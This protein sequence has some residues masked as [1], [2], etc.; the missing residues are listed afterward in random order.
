MRTAITIFTVIMAIGFVSPLFHQDTV[1]YPANDVNAI[2]EGAPI[3]H[4]VSHAPADL[5]LLWF[6]GGGLT[7]GAGAL[8]MR[9]AKKREGKNLLARIAGVVFFIIGAFM[10]GFTTLFFAIHELEMSQITAHEPNYAGILGSF[11][12]GLTLLVGSYFLCFG[13]DRETTMNS[14]PH[15]NSLSKGFYVGS[16]AIAPA[17]SIALFVWAGIRFS[18]KGPLAALS[19]VPVIYLSVVF[20]VLIYK[21]WSGIQDGYARTTPGKAVGFLFI[22]F[23]NFYWGFQALWGFSKD[24]NRYIQRHSLRAP[25]LREGLFLWYF[26][27]CLAI[28]LVSY[29]FYF[30]IPAAALARNAASLASLGLFSL[31][32]LALVAVTY[33]VGL[34]MVVKICDGV[35]ALSQ[36]SEAVQVREPPNGLALYCALGEFEGNKVPLPTE[37]IVI[38]RNPAKAHLVFAD[39]NVSGTHAFVWPDRNGTGV[40]VQD[41][42]STHGTYYLDSSVGGPRPTWVRIGKPKLLMHSAHFRLGE[43]LAEFEVTRL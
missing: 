33:G 27:L 26:V 17:F 12:V 43:N 10:A 24:Y 30:S 11:A 29:I 4:V 28:Y 40:W 41:L 15:N 38:G 5:K 32:L 42:Q 25:K 16:Y 8:W 9:L 37:G 18:L 23:F 14:L 13:K 39:Q 3:D 6:L 1:R 34:V 31:G 21:M 19:L 36:S 7:I 35:N 2:I 22:P 20:G